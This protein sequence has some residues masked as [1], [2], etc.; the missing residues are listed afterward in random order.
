MS[1][2]SIE[3]LELAEANAF[4]SEHHRHHKPVI[5]QLFSIGAALDGKIVGIH[6]EG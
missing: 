1:K 5:G 6:H 4:V 2:M 3:R